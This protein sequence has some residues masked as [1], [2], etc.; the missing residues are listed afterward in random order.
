MLEPNSPKVRKLSKKAEID[1]AFHTLEGILIG[2]GID[3]DLNHS[4]ILELQNW[5]K[6]SEV[7]IQKEII[8]EISGILKEAIIS[9]DF[10]QDNYDS[11]LWICKNINTKS[12]YYDIITSDM[13]R[14]Q[15]ILHGILADGKITTSEIENLSK[16]LFE[17]EQ[18]KG[19]YPYDEI[20]SVIVEVLRDGQVDEEE[21][22]FLKVFFS[23]FIDLTKSKNISP[24][25]M[26][27]LKREIT[28]QGICSLD[29]DIQFD[30]KLFCF[31]GVSKKVKRAE[32]K[33][34]VEGKHGRFSEN[35]RKDLDY[36]IIGNDGNPCWVYSCYG[37]KVEQAIELRKNGNKIIIVN[38]I[39]FWD[40]I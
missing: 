34:L 30:D 40:S 2:I 36:L 8:R 27:E 38:E 10:S 32:F 24:T 11:L 29:P 14:L 13:Q 25:E 3:D 26:I 9:K 33:T 4:E 17:N 22:K 5:V 37:R 39:D 20:C 31:T 35:V 6:Q 23:E 21:E 28:I 1:K 7:F 15:G 12:K 19:V 18:L 16:W